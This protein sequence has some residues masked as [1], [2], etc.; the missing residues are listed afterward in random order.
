MGQHKTLKL[1]G[2]VLFLGALIFS[3]PLYAQVHAKL[4]AAIFVK[5]L[6][7]DSKLSA[8]KQSKIKFHIVI[9]SKTSIKKN[10]LRTDFSS[11]SKKKIAGKAII[12]TVTDIASLAETT[13]VDT[14][15]IYYLPDG[16]AQSTLQKTLSLAKQQKIPVLAGNESL[17]KNGAAVGITIANKKPQIIVN[18]KQS[19]LL[20]MNLSSQLL[21]LAKII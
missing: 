3:A 10:A 20:G 18:L 14:T 1:L 21:K 11:M 2:T 9:D 7:Y 6:N 5:L 13:S 19:K 16:T 17:T 12:V 15:H 4:Q 8:K